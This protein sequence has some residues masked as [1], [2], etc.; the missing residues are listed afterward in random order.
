MFTPPFR[1][2]INNLNRKNNVL[3][4]EVTNT[5]ANRIRDLD[6][7]GVQWQNFHDINFVNLNY[8]RFD[9]SNWPVADS[10]LLGPVTLT[11]LVAVPK[12]AKTN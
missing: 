1:V 7:R 4:V 9:A 10:G 6:Q 11:R 5:S 8:K 12:D 3:E 2:V